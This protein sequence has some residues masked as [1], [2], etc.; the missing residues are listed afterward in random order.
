[1]PSICAVRF[2]TRCKRTMQM[3]QLVRRQRREDAKPVSFTS[4]NLSETFARCN[5][6]KGPISVDILPTFERNS[7]DVRLFSLVHVT[8]ANMEGAEFIT[9]TASSH[10]GGGDKDDCT[11]LHGSISSIS[12]YSLRPRSCSVLHT[13]QLSVDFNHVLLC[14]YVP[15]R[16]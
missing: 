8:P 5:V 16:T 12:L 4:S 2:H 9:Y 11:S 10:Q 1:M 13:R 3:T 14:V 6:A 15:S 7:F